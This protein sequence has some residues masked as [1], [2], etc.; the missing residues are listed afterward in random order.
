MGTPDA[1]AVMAVRSTRHA[2]KTR[3]LTTSSPESGTSLLYIGSSKANTDHM[4]GA[5]TQHRL[6]ER[7]HHLHLVYAVV[8]LLQLR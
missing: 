7:V 2:W 8:C 1:A 4:V 3:Q 5:S 6:Q